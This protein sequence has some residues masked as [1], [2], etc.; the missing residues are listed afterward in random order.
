MRKTKSL[1]KLDDVRIRSH[2]A[3]NFMWKFVEPEIFNWLMDD[4]D[5][6]MD[7]SQLQIS[8]LFRVDKE[9]KLVETLDKMASSPSAH[10]RFRLHENRLEDGIH[11]PILNYDVTV[12]S[13]YPVWLNSDPKKAGLMFLKVIFDANENVPYIPNISEYRMTNRGRMFA[14]KCNRLRP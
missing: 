7:G 12:N 2:L 6:R 1:D 4:L 13:Y 5:F 14:A 9:G 11:G 10:L 3:N 8:G